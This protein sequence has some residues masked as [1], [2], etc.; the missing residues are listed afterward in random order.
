MLEWLSF[1]NDPL[2]RAVNFEM[3]G[4]ATFFTAFQSTPKS[5]YCHFRSPPPRHGSAKQV[6]LLA[7]RPSPGTF[8]TAI[9]RFGCESPDTTYTVFLGSTQSLARENIVACEGLNP[10]VPSIS[11]LRYFPA[12]SFTTRVPL[13][14]MMITRCEFLVAAYAHSNAGRSSRSSPSSASLASAASGDCSPTASRFLTEPSSERVASFRS[15]RTLRVHSPEG[16]V[17]TK[18]M[19][20]PRRASLSLPDMDSAQSMDVTHI[21]MS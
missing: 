20:R 11:L 10:D 9:S 16:Q 3:M 6:P 18:S 8:P 7:A 21:C 2:V 13:K 12:G 15:R 5:R 1:T 14:S 19:S 4:M 17:E